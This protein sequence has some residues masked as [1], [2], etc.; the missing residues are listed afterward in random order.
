MAK[1]VEAVK[2]WLREHRPDNLASFIALT[3]SDNQVSISIFAAMMMAFEAGRQFQADN[4]DLQLDN[5]C[6]Y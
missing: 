2:S 5:P 1:N 3:E 6:V 4:L